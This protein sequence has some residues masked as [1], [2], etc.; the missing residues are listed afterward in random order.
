MVRT[1][2]SAVLP[3]QFVLC[4]ILQFRSK[5]PCY[6]KTKTHSHSWAGNPWPVH[7]YLCASRN[8]ITESLTAHGEAFSSIAVSLC[9]DWPRRKCSEPKRKPS[10]VPGS[11]PYTRSLSLQITRDFLFL[12]L[13]P[14]PSSVCVYSVQK[15]PTENHRIYLGYLTNYYTQE[16]QI[17]YFIIMCVEAFLFRACP[18]LT[19]ATK[20]C[21]AELP[22]VY[23]QIY[24]W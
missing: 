11:K 13:G 6:V 21:D 9:R 14:C 22:L 15:N 1:A 17:L 8:L 16:K 18:A 4:L 20:S 24:K 23:V 19:S 10:L 7:V 12:Y 2:A 3:A 5:I